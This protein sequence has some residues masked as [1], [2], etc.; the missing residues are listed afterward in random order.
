MEGSRVALDTPAPRY[1]LTLNV[2]MA[3]PGPD[4]EFRGVSKNISATGV[5]VLAERAEPRGTQLH[6]EFPVFTATG[7]VIWTREVEP[8]PQALVG[9]KFTSLA[10]SDRKALV[11]LLESPEIG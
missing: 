6:L 8:S 2:R 7:E 11:G 5:L 1:D 9:M 4:G 3:P 10:R